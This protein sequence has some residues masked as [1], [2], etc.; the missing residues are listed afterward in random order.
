M[1]KSD[2]RE[3]ILNFISSH[4]YLCAFVACFI[5]HTV[6]FVNDGLL[7]TNTFIISTVFVGILAL[8]TVKH[9]IKPKKY[10][11]IIIG[12][13]MVGAVLLVAFLA[14]TYRDFEYKSIYHILIGFAIAVILCSFLKD[15]HDRE[16]VIVIL[17]IALSFVIKFYYVYKTSMYT[18]QHDLGAFNTEHGHLSYIQYIYDNKDLL[19]KDPRPYWQYYHPPLH[20]IIS[21]VWMWI[22]LNIFNTGINPA[23]E[24]IQTLTLFY[25]M[26]ITIT[27]YKILKHF[28]LKKMALY[29]SLIIVAFHPTFILLSGSVN[30]DILSVALMMLSVLFALEWAKEPSFKNII[31]LSFAIGFAMMAK[32]ATAIVAIPIAIVMLTVFIKKCKTNGKE[33][34]LQFATLGVISF[35]LGLGY[36]LRNYAKFRMPLTYVQELSKDIDQFL[37]EGNFIERITD[38]SQHQW[39]YEFLAWEWNSNV[40]YNETNPLIALLKTA[41]F[42]ESIREGTFPRGTAAALLSTSLFWISVAIAAIAFVAMIIM[43]IR[44]G[45]L[46]INGKVLFGVFYV[47]SMI[48]YY[49]MAHDY[50]FVCTISMRYVTQTIIIGA[51]FLGVFME[52]L[53]EKNTLANKIINIALLSASILFAALS[54]GAYMIVSGA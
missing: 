11:K 17:I 54:T 18:R 39:E 37:G 32:I 15:C 19:D 6:T 31:K 48:S 24:G 21:A 43:L 10:E 53:K 30:N 20:H 4:P 9:Y 23:R 49:K 45:S 52:K 46:D 29:A 38:F 16:K 50:P 42:E 28:N 2:T 5:A 7:P 51:L 26:V 36:Q 22:N 33:L 34:V 35:P 8:Y 3:R 25:S 44:K 1:S 14:Y 47:A 40:G 12:V 13:A 41:I 27:S